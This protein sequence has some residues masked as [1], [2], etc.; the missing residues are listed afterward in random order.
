MKIQ[1]YAIA[2]KSTDLFEKNFLMYQN[3][4][5]THINLTL[6]TIP[7][8]YRNKNSPIKAAVKKEGELLLKRISS[9]DTLI[10]MDENGKMLSTKDFSDW[11][12]EWMLNSTNPILAIGGP[13]GLSNAVHQRAN[14]HISLSKM[15]LPHAL[16]PVILAEQIYRAWT[17]LDG[18]P[19][20]R[21]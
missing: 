19:Y 3:R 9:K 20:H 15:T 17:I 16:V 8:A 11:M 21:N 2:S 1:I 7:L 14:K 13:D 10:V 18:K 4:L 5:P 12:D 6:T